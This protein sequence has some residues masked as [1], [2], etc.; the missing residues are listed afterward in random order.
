MVVVPKIAVMAAIR[1]VVVLHAAMTTIPIAREKLLAIVMRADPVGTFVRRTRPVAFMPAM[2]SA[3]GIPISVHPSEDTW[4]DSGTAPAISGDPFCGLAAIITV[5]PTIRM[6]IVF[7]A[8]MVAFP[9]PIEELLAIVTRPYPASAF[10]RGTR[11]VTRV[12]AIFAVNRVLITVH[13]NVT[14]AGRRGANRDDARRRRRSDADTD[15]DL[16]AQGKSV[17]DQKQS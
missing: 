3:G 16:G 10:I 9:I 4:Q 2:V 1:F 6:V 7:D 8:A 14:G 5:V 15:A 12:P 11:P 13:P 17:S